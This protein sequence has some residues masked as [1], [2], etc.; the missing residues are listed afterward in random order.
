MCFAMDTHCPKAR[1]VRADNQ[2]NDDPRVTFASTGTKESF[3]A[4][5][6]KWNARKGCYMDKFGMCLTRKNAL[7][8]A[9]YQRKITKTENSYINH[10]ITG[11]RG[12]YLDGS[13]TAD[14]NWVS[15][16]MFRSVA[17]MYGCFGL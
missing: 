8:E 4:R 17:E 1:R 2:D 15:E 3:D 16:E 11:E 9:D 13:S 14:N 12:R 10:P 6:F 5:G 7:K